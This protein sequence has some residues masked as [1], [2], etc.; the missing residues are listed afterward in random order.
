MKKQPVIKLIFPPLWDI[1]L[2][3]LSLPQLSS[4][5]LKYNIANNCFDLNL[6][7][8]KQLSTR[9]NLEKFYVWLQEIAINSEINTDVDINL[10][11]YI[12]VKDYVKLE[13]D[14]FFI[15][16]MNENHIVNEKI[17]ELLLLFW[18]NSNTKKYQRFHNVSPD[19]IPLYFYHD[20][21]YFNSSLS[22][23]AQNSKD[24]EFLLNDKSE[25]PYYKFYESVFDNITDGECSFYGLSITGIN[26]VIP[27]FTLAKML[28]EKYPNV[29]IIFGGAW[30]TQ[31]AAKIAKNPS[32][33]KDV[34]YFVVG[35]GEK[36]LYKILTG[37]I[38]VISNVLMLKDGE[39][40]N[41][42]APDY[43]DL[44]DLPPPSFIDYDLNSYDIKN[45]LPYQS[46]RGC[47]W[48]KCTYCSYHILDPFYRKKTKESIYR[49]LDTLIHKYSTE[50]IC[51]V[52]S[53]LNKERLLSISDVI[54]YLKRKISWRGFSK[55]EKDLTFDVLSKASENGCDFLIWGMESGSDN[56]LYKI[57]KG[58]N[59]KIMEN[60]LR[61]AHH[62]GIHNRVCVMYEIPE[63]SD[64]DFNHTIDFLKR[65][66]N[67]IGSMSFSQFTLEFNSV[68]FNKMNIIPDNENEL[69]IGYPLEKRETSYREKLE[70]LFL[71][72]GGFI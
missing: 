19:D 37:N 60:V 52:D 9:K 49:D 45:T 14:V 27:A 41:S 64:T 59:I 20:R 17:R 33:F 58:T 47:S 44:D 61:D 39:I 1:D 8:W 70:R 32:L 31:L 66:I 71:Q 29:K 63:E 21:Y 11:N 6:F 46:S 24:I 55:L 65:N 67:Y 30:V 4:Y 48:G 35:E 36:A 12:L 53:E 15:T 25:N 26:Q 13:F 10:K 18:F 56:I 51:F 40:M 3:Y 72:I 43:V 7:F 54:S 22:K 57:R 68:M 42:K 38:E 50:Y 69:L 5:L 34:D 2:P 23:Y 28:K 62:A 16:I